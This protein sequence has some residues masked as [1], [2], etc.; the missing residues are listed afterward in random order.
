[1]KEPIR[2]L[3][4]RNGFSADRPP[5]LVV[6]ALI[7]RDCGCDGT[8]VLICQRKPDQPMSLK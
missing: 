6:A 3:E 8:E 7:L 4:K 2:K 5:R 1:V